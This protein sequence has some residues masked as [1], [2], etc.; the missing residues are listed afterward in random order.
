M[1]AQLQENFKMKCV[2]VGSQDMLLVQAFVYH[3]HAK[4]RL[5]CAMALRL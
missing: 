4:H 2:K 3:Q 1:V 5:W